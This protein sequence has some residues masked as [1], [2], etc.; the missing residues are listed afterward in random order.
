MTTCGDEST[1]DSEHRNQKDVRLLPGV[2]KYTRTG[3][4]FT[5]FGDEE[6]QKYSFKLLPH[7]LTLLTQ[8]KFTRSP[9]AEGGLYLRYAHQEKVAPREGHSQ[10]FPEIRSRDLGELK[11]QC[12]NTATKFTP[13]TYT[14]TSHLHYWLTPDELYLL[15]EE[16]QRVQQPWVPTLRQHIGIHGLSKEHPYCCV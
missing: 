16:V 3:V 6:L 14:F 11:A 13:I 2:T 5:S 7:Q 8:G 9:S 1:R 12:T 4:E 15:V 10:R